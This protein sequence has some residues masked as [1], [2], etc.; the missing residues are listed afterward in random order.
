MSL[1]NPKSI[2][3]KLTRMNVLVS[4][5]A[6]ALAYVSFL[7][8]DLYSL[9]QNLV[10]SLN[11]EA[12]IVG[13]NSVAALTFD[14]PQAAENTLIALR[15]SPHILSAVILR[16]DGKVFAQYRREKTYLPLDVTKLRINGANSYWYQGEDLFVQRS[17]VFDGR[18]V[19]AVVLE[20]ETTDIT[21]RARQF[22]LISAC[23]LFLSFLAA[24]LATIS[25]R[26]LITGPLTQ[27]AGTAQVVSRD[28]NYSVRA[29]TP[30]SGDE[31]ASLV[32]SFNG[33]LEQ[34][35][36]RDAALEES[37]S[38]LERRV[39]ERTAE[40][41]AA[42]KELEAFSYS[43]AHDLRGPL[44]QITN[45]GFIL[46]SRM[47]EA[48]KRDDSMLV[49]KIFEGSKRM[50]QL[51]DDLLNLS[52]ATSTPL[53]PRALNL[54]EMAEKIMCELRAGEPGPARGDQPAKERQRGCRRRSN[55]TG[56]R[57]PAEECLEVHVKTGERTH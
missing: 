25:T 12:T 41:S 39:K 5:I 7:F 45:I 21:S 26:R 17:I 54:T 8:Y 30:R 57:E 50:S 9:R 38:V 43:V 10:N 11:T 33:M 48:D 47:A 20:A 15:R 55:V 29:E 31:I 35:E 44:Q 36:Q 16:P 1:W 37:R 22:G 49:D 52:R 23:I 53:R 46:Q 34:I 28:Q 40:L 19:G 4:G 3:G 13:E 6:L 24:I 32:E 14:D 2:S 42:N 51:I 27:L 56:A 18:L